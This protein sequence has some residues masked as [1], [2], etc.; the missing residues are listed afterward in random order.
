MEVLL[1]H[2]SEEYKG[3]CDMDEH[4][5]EKMAWHKITLLTLD[6]ASNVLESNQF[7]SVIVDQWP[8]I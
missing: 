4:S 6:I 3:D 7:T 1:C 2:G 8:Q 5:L